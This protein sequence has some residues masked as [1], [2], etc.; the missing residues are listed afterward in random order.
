MR[1]PAW[2]QANP[3]QRGNLYRTYA[4]EATT[5]IASNHQQAPEN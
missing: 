3:G 2:Q 5:V 1:L 4:R